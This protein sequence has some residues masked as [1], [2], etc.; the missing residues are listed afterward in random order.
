MPPPLEPELELA[1]KALELAV[2]KVAFERQASP[3]ISPPSSADE[4]P[5]RVE[6]IV[7]ASYEQS[8]SDDTPQ[9]KPV[10]HCAGCHTE[11]LGASLSKSQR[12][13]VQRTDSDNAAALTMIRPQESKY[14]FRT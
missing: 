12:L 8:V 4:G 2:H 3:S 6:P 14:L 1:D 10:V 11:A 13:T 7:E 9:V 5:Q